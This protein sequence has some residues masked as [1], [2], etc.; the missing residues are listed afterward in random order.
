[1][2]R[3]IRLKHRAVEGILA[4]VV[5]GTL[6]AAEAHHSRLLALVGLLVGIALLIEEKADEEEAE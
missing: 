1:M 3:K 6:V 2:K 5:G 4:S